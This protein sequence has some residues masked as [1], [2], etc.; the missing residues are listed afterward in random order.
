[1]STKD[2]TP[3]VAR[4]VRWQRDRLGLSIR[5]L[6]ARSGVSPS[7]ISDIERQAKSPTVSTLSA[8]AAAL[9]V[10]TSALLEGDSDGETRLHVVRAAERPRMIDSK[11][12]VARESFGPTIKGSKVEFLRLTIPPSSIAGPFPPHP[13]GTIEHVHVGSG[14]VR[15]QLGAETVTLGREDYCTCLADA[16]HSFDN[17]EGKREA[18]LYLIVEPA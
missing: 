16:P 15:M 10:P 3:N 17:R 14:S 12:G 18:R 1:M 4:A 9:A 8:L 13:R 5:D 7:M 6:A 2:D 11:S